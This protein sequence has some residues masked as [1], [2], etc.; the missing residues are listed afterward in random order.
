M[1]APTILVI[2]GITGDLAR[3]KLLPAI[4]ELAA[5][6]VLPDEFQVV[7]ITRQ[8]NVVV[9]TLT[10]SSFVQR[11]L[12]L[13]QM[14]L[15]EQA[16]YQRLSRHLA[17]I[18]ATLAA[19]PQQL[20]Y[21]SVP[22]QVARPIIEHL[23][24][25]GFAQGTTRLL[26]EKPFGTDLTS[27]QELIDEIAAHFSEQQVYRID[28]YL[29]KEM[30]Q[31]IMT[32]RTQN[33]LLQQTWNNRFISAIHII[34]SEAIGI[35]GRVQFYEQTGSLRD[36]V[37]SHLLQ[38]AALMLMD[39]SGD[40]PA[41]RLAALRH[42]RVASNQDGLMAVRGQYEGYKKEVSHPHSAVETF[43]AVRLES[44]A[45]QWQGVPIIVAN[46]KA[47]QQRYTEVRLTYGRGDQQNSITLRIQPRE[48]VGLTLQSKAPGFGNQTEQRTLDFAYDTNE[49]LPEAYERVLLD[50]ITNDHSLF[51][52]G[53]EVLETWRILAPLQ[54]VWQ[55]TDDDLSLY[56]PGVAATSLLQPLEP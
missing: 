48:G 19:P 17:D 56:Q 46:G 33:A 8:S 32:F 25:A 6:G 9:E 50:A 41:A 51:A 49:R 37:Q 53:A 24:A 31:N 35:E 28:H 29:A 1:G 4:A 38:L 54:Q 52:S 43:A 10:D 27:A 39:V 14:D 40:V 3:R 21:I 30:T 20:L 26:L 42:L 22:P 55:M 12:S 11:H 44:A 7:G 47:L 36:S 5:A 45:P 16:D 34:A 13:F 15:A 23:A 18:G 2:V